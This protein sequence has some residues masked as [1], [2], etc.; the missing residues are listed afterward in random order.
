MVTINGLRD[1][2]LINAYMTVQLSRLCSLVK[3]SS[4]HLSTTDIM[5]V[6]NM[7]RSFDILL[8][9]VFLG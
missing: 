4:E 7:A 6:F 3:F 1:V 9:L 5:K 2:K 8:V